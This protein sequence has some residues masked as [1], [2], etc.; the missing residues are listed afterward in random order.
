MDINIMLLLFADDKGLKVQQIHQRYN[1]SY[2][3][4][5]LDQHCLMEHMYGDSHNVCPSR[6]Y[7]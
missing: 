4:H 6:E 1:A 5:L 7:I 3:I 2:L